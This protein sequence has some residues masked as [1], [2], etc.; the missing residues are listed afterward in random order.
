MEY[1]ARMTSFAPL[2]RAWEEEVKPMV[3]RFR[4]IVVLHDLNKL[5][6]KSETISTDFEYKFQ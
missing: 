1:H 6:F 5:E 4:P 3:L 2:L